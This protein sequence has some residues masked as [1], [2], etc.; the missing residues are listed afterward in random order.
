MAAQR[1]LEVIL[2]GDNKG[3]KK[4]MDDTAGDANSLASRLGSALGG[5]ALAVGAA[6]VA[7][8]GGISITLLGAYNAA[9]ESQKVTRETERVIRTTGGAANVS[10]DQVADLGKS[11]SSATGISGKLIRST[12]NLLLTFTKVRNEVGEGNDVFNQ[13]TRLALDMSVVLGTDAS[14]A[15]IQLGKAL[16]DP[17]KGITALSRAGVSFTAEQKEQIKTLVKSG[18]VLGAQKVILKELSTE[19]GGAAEAASTPLMKLQTQVAGIATRIGGYLVPVVD[20]AATWLGARLPA[21]LDSASKGFDSFLAAAAPIA[22]DVFERLGQAG[23]MI[24]ARLGPAIESV[25]RVLSA[26]AAY[27]AP[28]AGAIAAIAGAAIVGS[29]IVLA[30]V[31]QRVTGFL[32]EHLG[33]VRLLATG[34]FVYLTAQVLAAAA[35]F[36]ELGIAAVSSQIG[37]LISYLAYARSAFLEVA[38]AQGVLTASSQVLTYAFGAVGLAAAALTAIVYGFAT[39]G[40]EGKK[41]ADAF[42]ASLEQHVDTTNLNDVQGEIRSITA[43]MDEL[44]TRGSTIADRFGGLMDIIIP[45][46]DVANS[47]EDARGELDGLRAK[48]DEIKPPADA[49]EAKFRDMAAAIAAE[50]G[51]AAQ[52]TQGLQAIR[53]QLVQLAAAGHIDIT[54]PGAMEQ[55]EALRTGAAYTTPTVQGLAGAFQSVAASTS[56]AADAVKGY[57]TALDELIG[58]HIS[59]LQAQNTWGAALDN[60]HAKVSAG[61]NL[62]DAYNA[63]NREAS[64]AVLS[65]ADSALKYSVSLLEEGQGLGAASAALESNRARLIATMVQT[66]M[67]RAA[68]SAYLDTLGLTP[69]NIQTTAHMNKEQAQSQVEQLQRAIGAVPQTVSVNVYANVAS[70]EAALNRLGVRLNDLERR[71]IA[72]NE[73]YGGSAITRANGGITLHQYADGAHVAQI[74]RAGTMRLWAEPE[75]GGEA[76]I[77]LAGAKRGQSTKILAQVADMFGYGLTQTAGGPGR[78]GSARGG[79]GSGSA[80]Q[81]IVHGYVG[82]EERLGKE[83]LRQ[84]V[85][86]ERQGARTPWAN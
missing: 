21:A 1:R 40:E 58:V 72:A 15:A 78:S 51:P 14:G 33:L 84:I 30:D 67:T 36:A 73:N 77:P 7:A 46:H 86:A 38:A 69:D 42:V 29:F 31:I 81:V 55:L 8:V 48:L 5:G 56:T 17:V 75:T 39:A 10:A 61:V 9:A 83:I 3:A 79:R 41:K 63:R 70:A 26:L 2:A 13:A 74:A 60:V 68:A 80:M 4:A 62:M 44:G 19:F 22:R 25:G 71:T 45:F 47:A 35:A 11:L 32:A 28:V 23:E 6:A 85:V 52:T 12:E 66:G 18:D 50:Q 49:A 53:D 57:K 64:G 54:A 34:G 43:R 37:S 24:G 27:A 65:A 16:N 82:D 59:S 76:Y 20:A